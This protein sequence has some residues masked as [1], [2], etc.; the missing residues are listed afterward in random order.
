MEANYLLP[1]NRV[2]W[3][4]RYKYPLLISFLVIT[5]IIISF[6]LSFSSRKENHIVNPDLI[7]NTWKVE[8]LYKNGKLVI[9]SNKFEDLF[10]QV[11]RNGTAEWIK[12]NK[13]LTLQFTIS[14]DGTQIIFD[15]GMRIEDVDTIFELTP[16]TLR[17]GKKGIGT[18]YEYVFRVVG[19][20][21]RNF[22]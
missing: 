3:V 18:Y 16:T 22:I 19:V 2:S 12:G 17:F 10:F 6:V 1:Q 8:K 7:Y 13:R 15:D 9:N 4:S 5:V 21:D 20:R 11:N 14:P